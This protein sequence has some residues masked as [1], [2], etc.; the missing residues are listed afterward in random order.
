MPEG[1]RYGNFTNL[2]LTGICATAVRLLS[3]SVH[4]LGNLWDIKPS[5]TVGVSDQDS[6]LH[7]NT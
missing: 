1:N 6:K 2:R 5:W 3:I 7:F 4:K